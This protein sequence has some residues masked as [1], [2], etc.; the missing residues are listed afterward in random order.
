MNQKV[1]FLRGVGLLLVSE[2]GFEGFDLI[3]QRRPDADGVVEFLT[4][5][6]VG[7]GGLAEFIGIADDFR[8]FEVGRNGGLGS[9]EVGDLFFDRFELGLEG[10]EDFVARFPFGGFEFAA[11]LGVEAGA[12]GLGLGGGGGG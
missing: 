11:F 9:F 1:G 6:L 4:G 8:F 10:P 2:F 12:L 3:A 5:L 7:V